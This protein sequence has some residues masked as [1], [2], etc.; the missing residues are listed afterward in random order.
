MA[1]RK[2]YI[3]GRRGG[4]HHGYPLDCCGV[5]YKLTAEWC[6]PYGNWR[7]YTASRPARDGNK[8]ASS[9]LEAYGWSPNHQIRVQGK[10]VYVLGFREHSVPTSLPL[11]KIFVRPLFGPF[12]PTALEKGHG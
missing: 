2:S 1:K 6:I 10:E 3:W 4:A 8:R 9:G 11:P 12:I 5:V 7:D